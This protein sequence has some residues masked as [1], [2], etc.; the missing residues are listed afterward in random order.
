MRGKTDKRIIFAKRSP[1]FRRTLSGLGSKVYLQQLDGEKF[2]LGKGWVIPF[3]LMS[4]TQSLVIGIL[5][6]FLSGLTECPIALDST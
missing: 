6:I 3:L 2:G 1:R 4:W 5:L